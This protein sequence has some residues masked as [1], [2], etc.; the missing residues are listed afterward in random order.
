MSEVHG[1][2]KSTRSHPNG[3]CVEVGHV[4]GW[5]KSRFSHPNGDCVGVGHVSDHAAVRDSKSPGSG[6][7][8][9]NPAQWRAFL[10]AVKDDR[11]SV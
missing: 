10:A 1:W 11:F 9:A 2:R 3:N 7:V 4:V 6:H 5:R 8:T